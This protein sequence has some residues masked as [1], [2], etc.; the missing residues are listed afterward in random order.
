MVDYSDV[1]APGT[2][3]AGRYRTGRSLGAGGMGVILEATHLELG[4]PVAIKLLHERLARDPERVERFL[5]EARAAAQLRGEHVCRVHDCGTLEG[6]E[7]FMVMERL[8]GCDLSALV[9]Q[10]GPLEPATVIDYARQACAGIAEAHAVGIVHR[11]LKPT[12]IFRTKRPDGAP[13]IKILDF[14]LAKPMNGQDLSLTSTATVMG[15][16][17]Y[18]SPEQLKSSRVTDPRSDIWALGVVMYELLTGSPPFGGESITELALNITND[19]VPALPPTVPPALEAVVLRCLEKEAGKRYQSVAELDAALASAAATGM[20]APP[21]A[22][23]P[24]RPSISQDGSAEVPSVT[25]LGLSAAIDALASSAANAVPARR[26]RRAVWIVAA[27]AALAAGVAFYLV[28]SPSSKT[29]TAAPVV[30]PD[31]AAAVDAVV[32]AAVADAPLPVIAPPDA[33]EAT[34]DARPKRPKRKQ[35]QPPVDLS[36][37]RY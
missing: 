22:R 5:R 33:R 3:L 30:T 4:T 36:G 32:D 24:S 31:A 6:G 7:P 2:I 17:R 21:P 20:G 11:D 37:P 35:K 13:L 18:M 28:T 9:D 12:N 15:S 1:L 26:S 14:G 23:R 27:A 34:P 16:P 19:P 8:T 25:E 10:L 29:S